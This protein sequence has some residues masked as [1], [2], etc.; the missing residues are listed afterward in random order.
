MCVLC[1]IYYR[2]AND[3]SKRIPGAFIEP[4]Q[5]VV[6]P[7]LHHVCRRAVVEPEKRRVFLLESWRSEIFI[8]RHLAKIIDRLTDWPWIELVDDGLEADDGEESRGEA[9]EPGQSQDGD[10]QQRRHSQ[11]RAVP[12]NYALFTHLRMS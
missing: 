11:R 6:E 12:R 2:S 5:E 8:S 7:V 10:S 3:S 9:H 4:I 1:D